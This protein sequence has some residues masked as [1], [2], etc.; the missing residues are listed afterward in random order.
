[1]EIKNCPRNC[2]INESNSF[3]SSTT[4]FSFLALKHQLMSPTVC[5][6]AAHFPT[7]RIWLIYWALHSSQEGLEYDNYPFILLGEGSLK[8]WGKPPHPR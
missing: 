8:A 3:V 6:E 5:R 1:M 7:N 4:N 2:S